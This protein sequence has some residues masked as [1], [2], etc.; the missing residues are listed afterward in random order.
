MSVQRLMTLAGNIITIGIYAFFPS[1]KYLALVMSPKLRYTV[2]SSGSLVRT[3]VQ[4]SF[5]ELFNFDS[6]TGSI[7]PK[8][9]GLHL[10]IRP[11]T[12]IE[13]YYGI[14]FSP[15]EQYL[16]ASIRFAN[17]EIFQYDIN[18][19]S[20]RVVATG[21]D[22]N[23]LQI[24]PNGNIYVALSKRQVTRP[25]VGY[26]GEP[27]LGTIE[28][29]DTSSPVFNPTA[30]HLGGRYSYE[31]LPSFP[32]FFDLEVIFT[33]AVCINKS[34]QMSVQSRNLTDYTWDFGDGTIVSGKVPL[35]GK[36]TQRHTYTS[37]GTYKIH[38]RV[39]KGL[40]AETASKT[41][42]V[43]PFTPID[44]FNPRDFCEEGVDYPM[45]ATPLG[46][47]YTG[48][49][50]IGDRFSPRTAGVGNHSIKY[51]YT[52]SKGCVNEKTIVYQVNPKPKIRLERSTDFYCKTGLKKD[53]KVIGNSSYTYVW[54]DAS[55]NTMSTTDVMQFDK[56]G[57]L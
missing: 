34:I 2:S 18:T 47:T 21:N 10:K 48:T 12:D 19:G 28:N 9:T 4:P 14:E 13:G 20:E 26:F 55:G 7:A 40:V 25:G 27:Y 32:K 6:K 30:I 11:N 50:V 33:G 39:Y 54:K 3:V 37:A 52:D 31:G 35:G 29:P 49:G 56:P 23:A 15:N 44:N 46:G 57:S 38:V 43:D 5:L 22:A 41:I 51:A 8:S 17:A 45:T 36:I 53:I 24:A 16:Y 42:T 1:G